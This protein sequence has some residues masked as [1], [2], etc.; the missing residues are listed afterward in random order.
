MWNSIKDR[1]FSNKPNYDD[2]NNFY[3]GRDLVVPFSMSDIAMDDEWELLEGTDAR[4]LTT[5]LSNSV[6]VIPG[7]KTK[8]E[9]YSSYKAQI[10]AKST[11]C[12]VYY[13]SHGSVQE[14]LGSLCAPYPIDKTVTNYGYVV[15]Y[16]CSDANA[17]FA[18]KLRMLERAMGSGDSEAGNKLPF[19]Q[20]DF[21]P[22]GLESFDLVIAHR[23][24]GFKAI[25][26]I[27]IS[28]TMDELMLRS[29]NAMKRVMFDVLAHFFMDDEFDEKMDALCEAFKVKIDVSEVKETRIVSNHGSGRTAKR[30]SIAE[31]K[32]GDTKR[33]AHLFGYHFADLLL[34]LDSDKFLYQSNSGVQLVGPKV[35]PNWLFVGVKTNGWWWYMDVP[36]SALKKSLEQGAV[37]SSNLKEELVKASLVR[38]LNDVKIVVEGTLAVTGTVWTVIGTALSVGR[39]ATNPTRPDL[40]AVFDA[41]FNGTQYLYNQSGN[42]PLYLTK[43]GLFIELYTSTVRAIVDV[44][45]TKV[46][47]GYVLVRQMVTKEDELVVT[48]DASDEKG[49]LIFVR[50]ALTDIVACGLIGV[51]SLSIL[52]RHNPDWPNVILALFVDKISG[53]YVTVD[54]IKELA[55]RLRGNEVP[56]ASEAKAE[57]FRNPEPLDLDKQCIFKS[58]DGEI[59]INVQN[60]TNYVETKLM[61]PTINKPVSVKIPIL[62]LPGPK[63]APL[64]L[65]APSKSKQTYATP[66][67]PKYSTLTLPEQQPEVA[68]LDPTVWDKVKAV[69]NICYQGVEALSDEALAGIS[70]G[71]A[72]WIYASCA[73]IGASTGGAFG[74]MNRL[75]KTQTVSEIAAPIAIEAVKTVNPNAARALSMM[76]ISRMKIGK[77]RSR[78]DIIQGH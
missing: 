75:S 36:W 55:S 78:V 21:D 39:L 51:V 65:P 41:L 24:G 17:T 25:P 68:P 63:F 76:P 16:R 62:S 2:K 28:G 11:A 40:L 46:Y 45:L 13:R 7:D 69:G 18:D 14:V 37:L 70:R 35:Q 4:V 66:P 74:F 57:V 1:I 71:D 53:G 27:V 12:E 54:D 59:Y 50:E 8:P 10:G 49:L 33:S 44:A 47:S 58:S 5:F 61:L 31:T 22:D 77:L 52:N 43:S 29:L 60:L 6:T 48:V 26:T 3:Y 72:A 38:S 30:R 73:I 56:S 32:L 67:T 20:E 23:R 64:T 34:A 42:K 15:F 9:F 19:S